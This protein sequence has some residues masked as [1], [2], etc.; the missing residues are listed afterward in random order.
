MNVPEKLK[1]LQWIE[2]LLPM[3]VVSKSMHDGTGYYID[4]RLVLILIESNK[5][6]I[7]K[8]IEYPFEIWNGCFFPIEKIKQNAVFSRFLF[9]ENHPGLKD[10]LYLPAENEDF[11]ENVKLILREIKKENPLFGIYIKVKKVKFLADDLNENDT[12]KPRLFA[13]VPKVVQK[14]EI[15][16]EKPSQAKA[17]ALKKSKPDKKKENSF[18]LGMLK[19]KS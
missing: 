7:H 3:D 10:S 8:G 5:T 4:D 14:K 1:N 12:S 6:R 17:K 15:K 19:K 13:D 11:A 18:L 2:E 16:I 9:L